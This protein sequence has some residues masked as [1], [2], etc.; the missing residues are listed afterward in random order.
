MNN[1]ATGAVEH[2]FL[3]KNKWWVYNVEER[4]GEKGTSRSQF[5][6]SYMLNMHNSNLIG[7]YK[8]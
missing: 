6:F 2:H 1:K 7:D 4:A 5:S 8:K 3:A